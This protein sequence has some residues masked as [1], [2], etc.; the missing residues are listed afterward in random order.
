MASD[1]SG[2]TE[3]LYSYIL[4]MH[5]VDELQ[6]EP[7]L[8]SDPVSLSLSLS[9]SQAMFE[10]E[11]TTAEIVAIVSVGCRVLLMHVADTLPGLCPLSPLRFGLLYVHCISYFAFCLKI[12]LNFCYFACQTD[13]RTF[14]F[15]PLERHTVQL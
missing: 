15:D 3:S 8:E 1:L 5:F 13:G 9:G 11:Q 2:L 4:L 10:F 7:Q 12:K 14:A 6:P